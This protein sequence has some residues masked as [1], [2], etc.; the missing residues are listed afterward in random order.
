MNYIMY[1]MF[2]LLSRSLLQNCINAIRVQKLN[3]SSIVRHLFSIISFE[4]ASSESACQAVELSKL[5]VNVPLLRWPDGLSFGPGLLISLFMACFIQF[6]QTVCFFI[7]YFSISLIFLNIIS[8]DGLYI[9]SSALHIKF[10]GGSIEDNKP[11]Y[12]TRIPSESLNTI[13][14][15]QS[16]DKFGDNDG[17]AIL[18]SRLKN[19][20]G[21]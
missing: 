4:G 12:I 1:N 3:L 8:V 20:S 19:L 10:S 9:T 17:D 21:Q 5:V 2:I 18:S 15:M 14:D 7:T 6:S 11:Y 16:G 13:M